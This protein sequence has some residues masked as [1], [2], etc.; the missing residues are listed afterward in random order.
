MDSPWEVVPVSGLRATKPPS[1]AGIK[2]AV[3]CMARPPEEGSLYRWSMRVGMA[4]SSR[5]PPLLRQPVHCRS[6]GSRELFADAGQAAGTQSI[7][8]FL[9]LYR[10]ARKVVPRAAALV[11]FEDWYRGVAGKGGDGS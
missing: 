1:S 11:L 7:P 3:N 10:R 9:R 8:S 6:G 4:K 5:L 2:T